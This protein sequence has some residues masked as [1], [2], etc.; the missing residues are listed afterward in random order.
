[1]ISNFTAEIIQVFKEL[2]FI[3]TDHI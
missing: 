3:N 2:C 1:M